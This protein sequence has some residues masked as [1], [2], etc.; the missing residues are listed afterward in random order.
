MPSPRVS[1]ELNKG[2]YFLTFTTKN[3]FYI[4]DRH[5]RWNIIADS[6]EFCR[7]NKG[8][9][10][11][12]FVFMLNHVHLIVESPDV[13]GFIRDFKQ[14]TAKQIKKNIQEH[15]PTIEKLFIDEDEEEQFELWQKTNLPLAIESDK[16]YQQK[17]EYIR[18]N[19]VRKNYVMQEDPWYW[20]SANPHCALQSDELFEAM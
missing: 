6:L 9:K 20:S 12:E 10:I 8:L 17:T 18:Y 16:F 5:D 13:S 4:F 1:K 19:P 7:K 2:I 15:E 3:W 11:Y 14:F